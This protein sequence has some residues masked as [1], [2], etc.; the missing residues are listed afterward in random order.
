MRQS[1]EQEQEKATARPRARASDFIMEP[2]SDPGEVVDEK[3]VEVV[4]EKPAKTNRYRVY[5]RNPRGRGLFAQADHFDVHEIRSK[6]PLDEF[7]RGLSERGFMVKA[8]GGGYWV[9]PGAIMRVE[10]AA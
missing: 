4:H 10:Q 8:K 9:M 7:A 3:P 6:K 1:Q 2:S 5:S